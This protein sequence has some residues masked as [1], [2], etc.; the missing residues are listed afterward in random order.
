M[1]YQLIKTHHSLKN[2]YVLICA[3]NACHLVQCGKNIIY[4]YIYY[5]YHITLYYINVYI[6]YPKFDSLVKGVENTYGS[7]ICVFVCLIYR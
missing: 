7:K 4:I 1:D 2:K 5:T 6:F 3:L